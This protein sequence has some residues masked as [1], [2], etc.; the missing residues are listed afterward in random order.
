PEIRAN[1]PEGVNLEIAYDTSTFVQRSVDEVYET[2]IV[3]GVLVV[4]T[5]FVFLRDWRATVIPLVAIPVSIIGAFAVLQVMGFSINLLTLLAL[6]LAVGLVVDDA[7][8]MLENI[9]R[10][11]EEGEGPIHAAIF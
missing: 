11:I 8:V 1:L 6:V 5:I 3:A 10:R 9:Y 4:L 2:L 7:I